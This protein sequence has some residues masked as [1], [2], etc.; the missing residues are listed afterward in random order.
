MSIF[1]APYC[2]IDKKEFKRRPKCIL[3]TSH[4]KHVFMICIYFT[5]EFLNASGNEHDDM[6]DQVAFCPI[7]SKLKMMN[8]L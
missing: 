7:Q 8:E 6:K 4:K 2:I 1:Q 5:L 3:R